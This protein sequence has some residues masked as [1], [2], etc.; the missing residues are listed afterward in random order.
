MRTVLFLVLFAFNLIIHDEE[1][2]KKLYISYKHRNYLIGISN[3]VTRIR[4]TAP[5]PNEFPIIYLTYL[6]CE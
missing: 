6:S 1:N 4:H 5:I 2:G 3:I